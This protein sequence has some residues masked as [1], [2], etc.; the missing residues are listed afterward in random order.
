MSIIAIMNEKGGVGK[1][2]SAINLAYQASLL[3]KTLILDCEDKNTCL[4]KE[5]ILLKYFLI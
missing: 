2:T 5:Y 3:G 1:T 4:E